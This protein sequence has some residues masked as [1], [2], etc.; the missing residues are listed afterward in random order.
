MT[1]GGSVYI[2]TNKLKTTLYIGVTSDLYN[3]I[4]QHKEHTFPGSFSDTYNLEYCIYYENFSSIE[5]AI[6]REKQ[7]KKWR[8]EK[9]EL[10]IN[11]I[12]PH[13]SDLWSEIQY[14]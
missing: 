12:N 8:R 7:I 1:R 4:L 2:M 9:K 6:L 10:L 11:S 3:R 14:W 13:W 5:E